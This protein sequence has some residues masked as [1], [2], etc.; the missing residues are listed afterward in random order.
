VVNASRPL[1]RFD[2]RGA[3]SLAIVGVLLWAFWESRRFAVRA[4][5]FP[6]AVIVPTLALAIVQLIRDLGGWRPAG[7]GE[8]LEAPSAA[9]G[10]RT[11][12]IAAWIVGMFAAIW[13]LGFP[14]ATLLTTFLYLRLGAREPWAVSLAL[15]V[16]GFLFVD[17]LFAGLLGVP[18]PPGRLFEWL[19]HG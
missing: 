14:L 5:L 1:L 4:G 11:A 17:G 8:A 12:E 19:R 16:G 9:S 13:L 3:F 7:D 2:G 15:S 18:F 10:R 6:W